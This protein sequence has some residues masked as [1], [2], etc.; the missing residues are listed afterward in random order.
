[1]HV[2]RAQTGD[3]NI[4]IA[5]AMFGLDPVGVVSIGVECQELPYNIQLVV[6]VEE[7]IHDLHLAGAGAE[8]ALIERASVPSQRIADVGNQ[9]HSQQ[10]IVAFKLVPKAVDGDGFIEQG[11]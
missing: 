1:M 5:L 6:D 9:H 4:L 2:L 11:F 8:N 7:M 3:L 10:L